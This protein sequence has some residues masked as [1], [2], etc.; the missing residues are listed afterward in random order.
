MIISS[1]TTLADRIVIFEEN[2]ASVEREK[3]PIT[4]VE[5]FKCLTLEITEVELRR[6][7]P[8]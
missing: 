6:R 5:L 2:S 7:G 3:S 1:T 8:N 4:S